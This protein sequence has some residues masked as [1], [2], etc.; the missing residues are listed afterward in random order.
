MR[1][2]QGGHCQAK[3]RLRI[4]MAIS[5]LTAAK[6]VGNRSGW[7][8]SNLSMQKLLYIA[9]MYFLGEH[10]RNPLLEGYFEAWDY[11][12]VHPKIYHRAKIFGADPVSNIFHSVA[13][14]GECEER[15]MLD[16]AVDQLAD[17][18]SAKLVAI[19]HWAEGAWA[20]NYIPGERGIII[21]NSDIYEEYQRRM[22]IHIGDQIGEEA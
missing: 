22:G 20:K 15:T 11:G 1:P 17:L 18:P 16:D 6:Y 7:K 21:S 8:L 9:H 2:T 13:D 10:D 5:A 19:T 14:I 12:P 3:S 4:T